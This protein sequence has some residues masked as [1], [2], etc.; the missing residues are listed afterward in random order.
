MQ[1]LITLFRLWQRKKVAAKT[2]RRPHSKMRKNLD[3]A[4][5]NICHIIQIN[6][7]FYFTQLTVN[8]YIFPYI[9][10]MAYILHI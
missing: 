3:A 7:S 6:P 4:Y 5:D 2:K 8:I 1:K 10:T 9:V